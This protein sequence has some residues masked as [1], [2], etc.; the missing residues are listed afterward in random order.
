MRKVSFIAGLT[1][2]AILFYLTACH[3]DRNPLVVGAIDFN[4]QVRPILSDKC[5]KCHGPDANKREAGLRLDMKDAAYA[6]LPEDSGKYAIVPGSLESSQL[7]HRIMTTDSSEMMPPPESN[8]ALTE[9]EKVILTRWIEQGAA[10]KPHWAFIPPESPEVPTLPGNTWAVNEIDQFV[11]SKMQKAGLKPN[12]QADKERLLKRVYYDLT[13]LPPDVATQDAFLA[14]NAPDAYEKIVD[15]LLANPHYGEKMAMHW[16]DVA[17]YADSHGYQDDGPRTMWPWRDWV[18]HAFNENYPYD[19][20]V[21]WQ[22]AGDLMPGRTKEMILAT[23]FNRNHKITQEGGVIDE[24]YRVEYVTDRTNTFGKAFLALTYECAHCHDHKY[25]PISMESYYGTFAFFNQVPEKGLYGDISANS[26]AD[27]PYMTITAADRDSLLSFI[28]EQDA[29]DVRVM[30]MKDSSVIRPTYILERGVYSAHG[31]EVGV[32]TPKA[33][34]PFD[35]IAYPK[36]RLGLAE[37]LFNDENPLTARVFVNRIWSQYFGRGLVKTSGD[38][39]MQGELPTHPELL[40]WLAVDFRTHGWDIKRLVKQIVMSATY[41]QSAQISKEALATDPENIYLSHAPRIRYAAEF[42]RDMVLSSGGLLNDMIGGPSVKTYQPDGIWEAATSGRGP[43]A[44]YVQDHD[45]MLYR[46]GMYQFIKRTVPPPVMLTFD[47]SNRD[48]CEVQRIK[49]NTPLQAL[50]MLNDPHVIEASRV[51]AE[52]YVHNEQT[53]E[54]SLKD[55]FQRIV[56]RKAR[57]QELE[58]LLEIY[59]EQQEHY[60]QNPADAKVFLDSGEYPHLEN[61]DPVRSAA[62][63]EAIQTI[64]NMEESITKT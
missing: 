53:P 2:I 60:Q 20:F 34:L 32:S 1:L 31:R 26:L 11:L 21:S 42:V 23:G 10:Y 51:M 64:Y 33:I 30:I 61:I 9:E 28:N 7:Y 57:E 41:R 48:Q 16:L 63:M 18:I 52:R 6:E 36:N 27:P 25:D 35:T 49:T 47:A 12:D 50:V 24:E 43:L 29:A 39:G 38:F 13:G 45:E 44:T 59:Q 8:L 22:L 17:R 3:T 58:V 14:N 55:A 46:R 62:L 15:Q 5:F 37:W 19:Q 56:C 4:Y 54:A 40:D